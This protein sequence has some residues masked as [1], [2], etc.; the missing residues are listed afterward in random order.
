MAVKSRHD[1]ALRAQGTL[2]TGPTTCAYG[3]RLTTVEASKKGPG[4]KR[5]NSGVGEEAESEGRDPAGNL[6]AMEAGAAGRHL[7]GWN[8]RQGRRAMAGG[9]TER[10]AEPA[11]PDHP[12]PSPARWGRPACPVPRPGGDARTER[13]CY[14][15]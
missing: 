7:P 15:A 10:A 5:L 13:C 3:E 4:G 1:K 8:Q 12:R 14:P 6:L 9:P 2:E 11:Q